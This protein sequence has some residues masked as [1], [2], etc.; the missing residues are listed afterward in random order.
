MTDIAPAQAGSEDQA[1]PP[2]KF[3]ALKA[4]G[5]SDADITAWANQK[6]TQLSGAGFSGG[7]VDSW[8]GA[9]PE[10]K[11][12][13]PEPPPT[14]PPAFVDRLMQGNKVIDLAKKA[15]SEA[16]SIWH[17]PDRVITSAITS[18]KEGFGNEAMG[19]ERNPA[20][21]Q[22]LRDAGLLV[23]PNKPAGP[24]LLLSDGIV[25]TVGTG[26]DAF[27]RGGSALVSGVAG[28][29]GQAAEELG[30]NKDAVKGGILA[31]AESLMPVFGD[32]HALHVPGPP[33]F[34]KVTR[35]PDG[36]T[37]RPS[38]GGLPAV[39]DFDNAAQLASQGGDAQ[40]IREKLDSVWN[41]KGVHPA[42]VTH[43]AAGDVTISQD[44]LSTNRKIPEVYGGDGG[45]ATTRRPFDLSRDELEAGITEAGKSDREN[46]IQAFGGDEAKAAEFERLDRRRNSSNPV[47]A[48]AAS[49]EFDAKFGDLTP[50]QERLV[51]GIGETGLQLEDMRRLHAAREPLTDVPDQEV[52]RVLTRGMLDASPGELRTVL[53]GEH[54]SIRA[55]EA[56]A[57][58][59]TAMEEIAARGLS[60]EQIETAAGQA[61]TARG[62]SPADAAEVLSGFGK[63]MGDSVVRGTASGGYEPRW[64]RDAGGGIEE[65]GSGITIT[66][67]KGG[68]F[69][70]DTAGP[71]GILYAKTEQ[72]A[73]KQVESL[74]ARGAQERQAQIEDMRQVRAPFSPD[75]PDIVVQQAAN[76]PRRITRHVDFDAAKAGDT[77][78]ASRVVDFAL[79]DSKVEAVRQLIGDKKPTLVAVHAEDASGRNQL[80]IAYAAELGKRLGLPV[81]ADIVQANRAGRTG[82]GAEYRLLNR[83]EF[84]G[85]IQPGQDY[86]LVDD[87]VTAG[88][89]L[90]DLRSYIESRGGNVIGATTLTAS[91]RSHIL[92]P[93]AS[94]L[95]APRKKFPDLESWLQENQGHGFD[96]LTESEARQF[97][98]YGS[99]SRIRNL[100]SPGEQAGRAG[101]TP[102]NINADLGG[103]GT[104]PA[105]RLVTDLD[106]GHLRPTV[107]Q[108]AAR[109]NLSKE[110]AAD[111]LD[112]VSHRP[113]TPIELASRTVDNPENPKHR[114]RTEDLTRFRWRKVSPDVRERRM[115]EHDQYAQSDYGIARKDFSTDADFI[116]ALEE[117]IAAAETVRLRPVFDQA[118]AAGEEIS[119]IEARDID[120]AMEN[121]ASFED[122][123]SD[124]KE[125]A[126]LKA[127]PRIVGGDKPEPAPEIPFTPR[128]QLTVAQR[129]PLPVPGSIQ[130]TIDAALRNR[131]RLVRSEGA[132]GS[133]GPPAVPPK[134]HGAG[135]P[136]SPQEKILSKISVG[137]HSDGPP[138]SWTRLYTL[139]VDDLNP[140]KKAIEWAV[141]KPG[142]RNLPVGENAYALFRLARGVYGK[143][144]EM[145]ERGTF[146]FNT[147]KTN[148]RGFRQI[149][150]T[151]KRDLNGVRAYAASKR[152][153]ELEARG[154]NSGL[155]MDAA[156]DVVAQGGDKYEP[157]FREM[158][159]YQNRLTEYLRDSGVI[160]AEAYKA[161]RAANEQY[162]PFFRIVEEGLTPEGTGKGLNSRNPIKGMTGSDRVIIDP[163]ESIIRNTY[164]Y[165]AL[166]DK[167][168]AGLTLVDSLFPAK[169]V[170]LLENETP[171]SSAGGGALRLPAPGET[172]IERVDEPTA[173]PV[174]ATITEFLKDHGLDQ[175]LGPDLYALI[176]TAA[177]EEGHTIR[178][179]RDGKP[180]VYRV[181]QDLASAWRGLDQESTNLFIRLMAGPTRLLKAGVTLDPSFAGRNVIRDFFDAAIN[182]KGAVFHPFN[183]LQGLMSVAKQDRFYRNWL[184]GGGAQSAL[185]SMDRR[186][187]QENLFHLNEDTGVGERFWNNAGEVTTMR[188]GEILSEGGSLRSPLAPLRALSE[189]IE[190]ATRVAEARKVMLDFEGQSGV[191][192]TKGQMQDAALRSREITL[193]FARI[194]AKTRAVNQIVAFFNPTIQST[195]RM[196]REFYARPYGATAK[197]VAWITTPS[198]LLWWANQSDPRWKEIPRWQKD[199]AWIVM[200]DK[201]TDQGP[202]E[203]ENAQVDSYHRIKDG[204]LQRNE[205]TIWRFP[206]PW[207]LG[208]LFGSVPERLLESYIKDNPDAWKDL[209][210]SISSGLTP[211]V[212]PTVTVPLIEQ[213]ANRSTFTNA[214][215]IPGYAEKLM[216]EYQYTPYTSE[217]AKIIGQAVGA[218]PGVR[219]NALDEN[220]SVGGVARTL[221]SPALI[222]NYVR[223]WTGGMGQYV[224]QIADAGLR[225]AGVV[226]DTKPEDA[227]SDVPFIR[228]FVVRYPS[229]TAQSIQDFV[230]GFQEQERIVQTYEE[231]IKVGDL[232]GADKIMNW[233]PAG[234]VR[235]TGIN[236]ALSNN[237]AL[238]RMVYENPD[239]PRDEKRQIIDSYYFNM[240]QLSSA[241]ND[242]L[243][244]MKAAIK[245]DRAQQGSTPITGPEWGQSGAGK[246]TLTPQTAN[247]SPA[248]VFRNQLS[249]EDGPVLKQ[250]DGPAMSVSRRSILSRREN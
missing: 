124:A 30:G 155:D 43:D 191:A 136:Q 242:M 119:L 114:L 96:A 205:G 210:K 15:G 101:E 110:A 184:K 190:N 165:I 37:T 227:L 207:Q 32:L 69:D 103:G 152:A 156:R 44:L 178:V 130:D 23:D 172:I 33:E 56:A 179:L 99:A 46:L 127:E 24:L 217:T 109:Y 83:A 203:G 8:L 140:V 244:T 135:E 163:I 198:V 25:Q 36:S 18:A 21:E 22:Q 238:I 64:V 239:I 144:D 48:D 12:P 214:P 233:A 213:F 180:E 79:D 123:L 54:G 171:S 112:E 91:A 245:E 27:L 202:A 105:R 68:G 72:G 224:L 139:V 199:L 219:E 82:Q 120:H 75:F 225:K 118:K 150:E 175:K 74:A 122:A 65:I 28:G 248:M 128:G 55:Q 212:F 170:K 78:A 151:V 164:S 243:R 181:S 215:I 50:E 61:M 235:L 141:G 240:I 125:R 204:R 51:Y 237:A 193:D 77:E 106:A 108:V 10:A 98:K 60:R 107:E 57:R 137:D 187:L 116:D 41:E 49:A 162:V 16:Y 192:L 97:L 229:A 53:N 236:T 84:D 70:I 19:I 80:P 206:K 67:N 249:S 13:A 200:T 52:L 231:R 208:I 111:L 230:H 221:S 153:I 89:T 194:G 104:S 186:Y 88:G 226:P 94:A 76:S 216:P 71:G 158:V 115:R 129:R 63:A 95:S 160:S 85:P 11:Q 232:A 234:M 59:Q 246:Q 134:G 102:G 17:A 176:R 121:G 14:V 148:G 211:S 117:H 39:R 26:I 93:S 20:F 166:A 87:H 66:P 195:D 40:R 159:S 145:L 185:V 147:L 62:Y 197:A 5:F 38:I 92:K 7:E 247:S 2:S 81:D 113:D 90:A 142:Y 31:L 218:F 35:G 188:E 3:Q 183:T 168:A 100:F 146:D 196:V 157:I 4:A 174:P 169:A 6:R 177:P 220:S 149:I 209:D 86:L 58:I 133:G 29:A 45:Q 201:W 189:L 173:H 161:M 9:T 223:A 182:T 126:A 47:T 154:I 143:A 222:D 1:A 250:E 138:M 132:G 167:N 228:A 241:G 42:E 131:G 73:I 34:A